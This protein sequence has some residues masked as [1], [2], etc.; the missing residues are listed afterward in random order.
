[1]PPLKPS[2]QDVKA[3]A[4]TCLV[5]TADSPEQ[6]VPLGTKREGSFNVL[7]RVG[8]HL[9]A[10]E[11]HCCEKYLKRQPAF[12]YQSAE[13]YILYLLKYKVKALLLP[14]YAICYKYLL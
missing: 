10:N 4:Q 13:N 14:K 9:Q 6:L 3:A 8:G 11:C 12:L 7:A 2:K 1:M 5:W